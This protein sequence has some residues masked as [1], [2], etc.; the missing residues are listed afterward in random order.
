M[1]TLDNLLKAM[2]KMHE[3]QE[4]AFEMAR[5]I[6]NLQETCPIHHVGVKDLELQKYVCPICNLALTKTLR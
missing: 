3:P 1:P 2:E 5:V 4:E 6:Y